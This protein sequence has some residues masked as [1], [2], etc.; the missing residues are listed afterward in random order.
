[1]PSAPAEAHQVVPQLC[2]VFCCRYVS[3]AA[4]WHRR[5]RKRELPLSRL[6]DVPLGFCGWWRVPDG[7]RRPDLDPN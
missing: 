7:W 6:H 4:R 1:M 2:A 3:V 5:E